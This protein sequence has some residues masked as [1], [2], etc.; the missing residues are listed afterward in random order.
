MSWLAF[1]YSL[2]SDKKS[3][4]R[5]ALWRRLQR[6]GAVAPAGNLY[7]LPA[8]EACREAF[9]WLLQETQEVGGTAILLEV[10]ELSGIDKEGLVA[11]FRQVR[12][13][14]YAP[15]LEEVAKLE[16][17]VQTPTPH[18]LKNAQEQWRKLRVQHQDQQQIDY[19]GCAKGKE[20]QQKL[21]QLEELLFEETSPSVQVRPA[22]PAQFQNRVWVTRPNLHVD[23]LASIW[24]IRRFI[25]AEATFQFA[26][27]PSADDV[28]FDMPDAQFGHSGPLCTFETLV[29]AFGIKAEGIRTI[30][31]IVHEIDLQDGRFFHPET[32][33]IA[34][35]LDGWRNSTV[36]D[37]V[38]VTL[39]LGL[40][41]GLYQTIT[42][43]GGA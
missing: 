37:E 34:A 19:F 29:A 26:N 7:F 2:P 31:E 36:A 38:L 28:T 42:Q 25:D 22:N 12:D 15:L 13:D 18:T 9:T 43:R 5:V 41:D 21:H 11:H 8:T 17:A 23:R 1:T 32:A 40:F 6:F 3:S 16:T 39:G 14:A 27:Q 20:M 4:A 10:E 33:G 24:L 35:I 30:A